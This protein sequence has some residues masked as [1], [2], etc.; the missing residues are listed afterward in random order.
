M[1]PVRC[2]EA[3]KEKNLRIGL[4]GKNKYQSAITVLI[5][6]QIIIHPEYDFRKKSN[7]VVLLKLQHSIPCTPYSKSICVNPPKSIL[8]LGKIT[9]IA[10]FGAIQMFKHS[11][12]LREG[13]S[14]IV[15][16]KE[17]SFQYPNFLPSRE[18]CLV[19]D[20]R[21]KA[22]KGDSGVLQHKHKFH[23]V[24]VVSYG[25]LS[26]SL[27]NPS[28]LMRTDAYFHFIREHVKDLPKQPHR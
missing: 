13:T 2:K 4:L 10:G 5:V 6:K 18:L 17:C 9:H 7:D 23:S 14:R 8:T 1:T 19:T 12:E 16:S 27:K 25:D 26:C 28:V 21:T 15:D 22:C 11:K 20:K 3:T 24:G